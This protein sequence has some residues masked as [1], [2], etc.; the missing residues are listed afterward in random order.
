MLTKT[1]LYGGSVLSVIAG[2]SISDWGVIIGVC[3]GVAGFISGEIHK[4]KLIKIAM[5][6]G[7]SIDSSDT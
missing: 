7:V 5:K 2:L 6:K 1:A 3:L 4:R